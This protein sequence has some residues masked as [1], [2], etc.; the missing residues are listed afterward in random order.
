MRASR[1]AS[2]A[3]ATPCSSRIASISRVPDGPEAQTGAARPDRGEQGLLGIS[4][5]DE[6]HPGRWLLEG[7]EQGRLRVLVHAVGRFDDGDPGPALDRQQGQLADEVADPAGP[8]AP[9]RR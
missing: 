7:L 8:C 5:Q 4:A 6:R 3:S 9:A 1:A 2:G